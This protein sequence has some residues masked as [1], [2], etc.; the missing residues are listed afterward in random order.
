MDNGKDNLE[1]RCPR[2]GSSVS[3]QYCRAHGDDML[4]PCWKIFDCWWEHF[5]VSAFL[6]KNMSED[7]F[8]RLVN[9]KPKPKVSSLIELI[10]RAKKKNS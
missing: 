7:D 5:D 8:V 10:E 2:L 9:A 6:K 4:L 3:F 1:C